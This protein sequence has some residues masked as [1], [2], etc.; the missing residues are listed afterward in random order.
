MKFF[1][2]LIAVAVLCALAYGDIRY[3]FDRSKKTLTISGTGDMPDYNPE[4]PSKITPWYDQCYQLEHI[5]VDE[6][7]TSIGNYAFYE[8]NDDEEGQH[9]LDV[10][11][12]IKGTITRIGA[13]AFG[14]MPSLTKVSIAA[15]NGPIENYIFY[16]STAVKELSIG[17]SITS[18]GKM[19]LPAAT[20]NLYLTGTVGATIDKAFFSDAS[21]ALK[22]VVLGNIGPVQASAF[23]ECENIEEVTFQNI[24][25]G[26]IGDNAFLNCKKLHTVTYGGT[27]KYIGQS[28][29]AGCTSLKV[30]NVIKTMITRDSEGQFV[31][32][33]SVETLK[34]SAFS[35]CSSLKSVVIPDSVKT[36]ENKVFSGCSNLESVVFQGTT[37]PCSSATE[38]FEGCGKLKAVTVPET[39][40]ADKIC[41]SEDVKKSSGGSGSG[42]G[43]GVNSATR[44]AQTIL[45]AILIAVVL[46]L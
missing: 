28:A 20:E 19:W 4:D 38:V 2:V 12:T 32:D 41:G 35:G 1:S 39:Y 22:K 21:G 8:C 46:A 9:D 37:D 7:I 31:V 26:F 34:S 5:V 27:I 45:T 16:R 33:D 3:N 25:D 40:G 43:S 18:F 42:S 11:I 36:I 10:D 44:N 6:G 15:L 23:T 14:R 17:G 13:R 30:G 29:F 24:K